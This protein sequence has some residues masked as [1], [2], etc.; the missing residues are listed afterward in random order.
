MKDKTKKRKTVRTVLLSLVGAI[1][2]I[3]TGLWIV[4]WTAP[5]NQYI[6]YVITLNR[7]ELRKFRDDLTKGNEWAYACSPLTAHIGMPASGNDCAFGLNTLSE[8]KKAGNTVY[9]DVYTEEERA[10]D[11]QLEQVGMYCLR[12]DSKEKKTFVIMAAGGSFTSVCTMWESLPVCAALS[13]MGYTCFALRYRTGENFEA[14]PPVEL[15]MKD[16][17]ACVSYIIDNA[18][19]FNVQTDNYLIGGFSAGAM[20]VSMWANE[21][22]GYAKYNL[23]KP[24]AMCLMY[25]FDY[26]YLIDGY[27][28]PT[29]CRYSLRDQ[30]FKDY[31]VF[32]KLS[33]SFTQQGIP[34]DFKGVQAKHGFGLGSGSDA[35]GW[36]DEAEVFWQENIKQAKA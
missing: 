22:I 18:D 29:F 19:E 23:P 4:G 14:K 11:P 21:K 36:V 7:S 6:P 26:N 33:E 27:T 8:Q 28:V 31:T 2:V 10:Q 20:L 15:L 3:V 5:I 12:G 25:G 9:Y 24:G 30:F 17:A 16:V 13:E 35:E 34:N 32:E 1:L